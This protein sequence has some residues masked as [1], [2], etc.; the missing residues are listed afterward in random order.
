MRAPL[1]LF[2]SE[3]S[4]KDFIHL[5]GSDFPMLQVVH[6]PIRSGLDDIEEQEIQD[7]PSK[8]LLTVGSIGTRQEPSPRDHTKT[9]RYITRARR[10]KV[11][12]I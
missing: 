5:Y 11:R 10:T 9:L 1:L 8:Y 12:D 6:P 3:T 7:I 2:V 4:K